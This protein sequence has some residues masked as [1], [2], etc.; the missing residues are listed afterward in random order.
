[1]YVMSK[2]ICSYIQQEEKILSNMKFFLIETF[3][4]IILD[5]HAVLRLVQGDPLYVF[6]FP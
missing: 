4:G 5:F 3:I 2:T 1:M 6:L